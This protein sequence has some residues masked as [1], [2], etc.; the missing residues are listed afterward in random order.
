[1]SVHV[2]VQAHVAQR[3]EAAAGGGRNH[4]IWADMLAA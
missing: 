2:A 3:R 1:M 4:N